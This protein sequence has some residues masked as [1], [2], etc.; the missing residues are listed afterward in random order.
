[1]AFNR[2]DLFKALIG[3]PLIGA[4]AATRVSPVVLPDT[5]LCQSNLVA[6]RAE[7]FITWHKARAARRAVEGVS[8]SFFGGGVA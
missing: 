7:R 3:V 8:V 1:M 6:L 2:R 5:F 4:W